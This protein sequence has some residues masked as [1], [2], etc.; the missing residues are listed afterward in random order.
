MDKKK[1]QCAWMRS[2]IH[3]KLL[4][5]RRTQKLT[6]IDMAK[7]PIIFGVLN[8]STLGLIYVHGSGASRHGKV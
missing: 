3:R 8:S 1:S 7:T 6:F 5:V 4:I 2:I